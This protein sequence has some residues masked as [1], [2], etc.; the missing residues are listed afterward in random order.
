MKEES[1]QT[2]ARQW[3]MLRSIPR[4]PIKAT[5]GEIAARLLDEGFEVSRRTV[6]RDLHTLSGQFPLLLDDRAKPYGWS[7]T[8]D[9]NFEFMPRLT[10]SQAVAL[11]L[12]QAHLQHLLPVSMHKDLAPIFDSAGKTLTSS[13]WRDWHKRTAVVPAT[14]PLL[15]PKVAPRVLE[16]V[17]QALAH[18][19]CIEGSY[20]T[21]GASQAKR[22]RIN[23]LGLIARGPILYL[24]CSLFDYADVKQLAMHRLSDAVE[25]PDLRGEPDGFDFK[26]Y[27]AGPGSSILPSSRIRL[28]CRFDAPAAEHLRES[29]LS[30]DQTWTD[31]GDNEIEVSATVVDDEQLRWWLLA[32]GSQVEV[33]SPAYLRSDMETTL[34]E[35][36]RRYKR[37]SS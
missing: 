22:W 2:L 35:A 8:K 27:V 29:P 6:E 13:G 14:L 28:V 21:K 20:R 37:R 15:P 18:K 5:T 30:T 17:Q 19:R 25:L 9:A 36:S 32:F 23:P 10:S 26:T 1:A 4:A 24:V 33:V 34:A 11:L 31:V 3:A 12:A 16:V 7:W